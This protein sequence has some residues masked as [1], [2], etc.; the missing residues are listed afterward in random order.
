MWVCLLPPLYAPTSHHSDRNGSREKRSE[1]PKTRERGE[2]KMLK[3]NWN[4]CGFQRFFFQLQFFLIQT[5]YLKRPVA[6]SLWSSL[7]SRSFASLSF[8]IISTHK[9]ELDI[10]KEKSFLGNFIHNLAKARWWLPWIKL[11]ER[12]WVGRE[13]RRER[14]MCRRYF[15]LF[16]SL[17]VE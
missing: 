8:P 12:M 4:F 11:I 9:D 3:I 5:V 15:F 16:L 6:I 2:I 13:M 14:E 7:L 1:K 10:R 17:N